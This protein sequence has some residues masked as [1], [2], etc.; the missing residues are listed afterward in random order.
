[1]QEASR[2]AEDAVAA[3]VEAGRGLGG[4]GRRGVDM[5][6]IRAKLDRQ[7]SMWWVIGTSVLFEV[8]CLALAAWH[9][10]TRDF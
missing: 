2:I 5:T 3:R 1:L 6:L 10:C 8:A 7:R 4:R 9:F